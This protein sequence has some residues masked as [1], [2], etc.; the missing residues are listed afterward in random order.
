[1]LRHIK[2]L[3]KPILCFFTVLLCFSP[4]LSQ[5][6]LKGRVINLDTRKPLSAAS[7]YLNNTSIGTVTNEE[8]LFTISNVPAQK[9][10]LVVSC[11][12]FETYVR[13]INPNDPVE[14]LSIALKPKTESL[15]GVEVVA[16]DPYGWEKWGTL[17]LDLFLGKTANRDN[18]RL[19]NPETLRFRMS[20]GN[21]LTVNAKEALLITNRSLGYIIQYKLENFEFDFNAS[22]LVYNGYA[23]FQD[24]APDNPKKNRQYQKE[25]MAIYGGSLL[26]FM[27]SA[28]ENRIEAEGF[29]IRNLGLIANP[30]KEKTKKYLAQYGGKSNTNNMS[31]ALLDDSLKYY[32][33]ILRQPDSLISHQII[34]GDSIRFAGENATVGLYFP[35]SLEISFQPFA[36]SKKE[37][38][39]IVKHKNGPKR[40]SQIVF[41]HKI[42][43]YVQPDGYYANSSDLKLTGYWAHWGNMSN[44]LPHNYKPDQP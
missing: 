29:E 38:A 31:I 5:N 35:D 44:L 32:R 21:V 12:G 8:G 41:I 26:H 13:I 6:L 24:L 25:R 34:S 33:R 9:F 27:R 30:E 37:E 3:T 16:P 10:S 36:Y 23:F 28:Y 2:T 7:V 14:A 15:T 17:F 18:C 4:A 1:M 19:E 40:I 39:Y 43:V 42:P 11:I 22:F 20:P